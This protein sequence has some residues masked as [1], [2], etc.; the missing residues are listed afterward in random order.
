MPGFELFGEKEKKHVQDVLDSGILMRYNFDGARNGHWK[1]KEFEDKLSALLKVSHTH[2]CSSGTAALAIALAGCGIGK[3]DEVIVTPFTFIATIE[4][5]IN[6]GAVPVFAD[7][8]KT[9]C[10]SPES[11]E[12]KITTKTKAVLPV[13]MCGSMAHIDKIKEVCIKNGLVLIEDACQAIG[14]SL[15]GKFAGSFGDMGCFSFD[16]VKTFTCGEGGAVITD[17]KELYE[18]AHAFSDHGHDHIGNDR[19]A[20]NH[21]FLGMNYRISELNAAVGLAQLERFDEIIEIQRKN[22]K[23]LKDELKNF[24]SVEL[25]EIPSKTADNGGFLSFLLP[26]EEKASKICTNL[27]ANGADGTFFWFH[28]NW[29]YYSN[30][31]HLKGRKT[32]YNTDFSA[33]FDPESVNIEKSDKIMSRALSML[34]KLSWT[35]SDLEKRIEAIKKSFK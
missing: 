16:F 14:A 21:P 11:I 15:D 33:S 32:L 23:I 2:L 10:L 29:H 35:Q 20:E 28:N 13:H 18:K 3:G 34:V 27:N 7:I 9:L 30:W 6:C 24:D 4:S 19:G 1:A 8:D 17:K 5:I 31:K 25:R 22:K 12:E 26:D